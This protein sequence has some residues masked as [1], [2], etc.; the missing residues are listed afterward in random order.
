MQSIPHFL[1]LIRERWI[2]DQVVMLRRIEKQVVQAFLIEDLRAPSGIQPHLFTWSVIAVRQHGC[3]SVAKAT[4]I[5]PA[6]R[7]NSALWLVRGVI[8]H[9]G[10][11][12]VVDGVGL[13]R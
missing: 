9:F 1:R 11:Y 4:Y 3:F 12:L 5:F 13:A 10:E 6:L 2:I 7:A 8:V